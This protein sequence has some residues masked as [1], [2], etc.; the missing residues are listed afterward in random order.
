MRSLR[1]VQVKVIATRLL[2]FGS[3][4]VAGYVFLV[5]NTERFIVTRDPAAIRQVYDFSHLRGDALTIAMKE[6]MVTGLEVAKESERVGVGLGHFTFTN[7]LGEKTLACREFSKMTLSFEAEGV[8]VNGERPSMEIEGDCQFT[9][10]LT[11][12][13]PLYVPAARILGE[14][15]ADGEFQFRDKNPVAVRFVNLADEWPRKWILT[16]VSLTGS[17][18]KLSI[19][20]NELRKLLGYPL[21]IKIETQAF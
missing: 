3:F 6:R 14:K 19:E 2:V 15:P 11:R 10:D 13:E 4:F 5:S 16:G 1:E 20:R 8:V 7:H 21:L 9:D 17:K 12:I 18:E